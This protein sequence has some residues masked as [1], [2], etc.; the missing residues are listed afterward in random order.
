MPAGPAFKV[1]ITP[2]EYDDLVTAVEALIHSVD[3][4]EKFNGI[5][6]N[7]ADIERLIFDYTLREL[8]GEDRSN[9]EA[10]QFRTDL[11]RQLLNFLASVRLYQDSIQHH[12]KGITGKED[13][14]SHVEHL[15]HHVF[16]GSVHYRIMAGLRNYAQHSALAVHGYSIG[17]SW[18]PSGDFLDFEMKPY[19]RVTD[20]ARD[21]TF[22]RKTID[23]LRQGPDEL[24][25]KPMIR[26]YV[27]SLAGL[28]G[29]FRAMTSGSLWQHH[30]QILSVRNRVESVTQL[31]QLDYLLAYPVDEAGSQTADGINVLKTLDDYVKFL[32]DR[33]RDLQNFAKRRV[34]Y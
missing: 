5:I 32:H 16:D 24:P 6:L 10:H 3:I 9:V 33:N 19:I 18:N 12:S 1:E 25:L 17:R 8:M 11:S 20:L 27:E 31:E 15:T 28:H 13:A 21:P 4:E 26:S 30:Q 2:Q 34:R 14:W 7:Y 29:K 22:R 23:E